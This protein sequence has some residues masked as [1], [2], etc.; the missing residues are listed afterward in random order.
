MRTIA[1]G[2][3]SGLSLRESYG[4]CCGVYIAY[5]AYPDPLPLTK[6]LNPSS[7]SSLKIHDVFSPRLPDLFGSTH[8]GQLLNIMWHGVDGDDKW[9]YANEGQL[10]NAWNVVDEYRRRYPRVD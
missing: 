8:Y 5:I 2:Q 4:Y 7:R 3:R 9:Y 6:V 1:L 10:E